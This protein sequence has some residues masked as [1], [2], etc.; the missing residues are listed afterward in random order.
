M[1]TR[2]ALKKG[3]GFW[4]AL[5]LVVVLSLFIAAPPLLRYWVAPSG[6]EEAGRF[7]ESFR[8]LNTLFSG[9]AADRTITS[10]TPEEFTNL[11]AAIQTYEGWKEGRIIK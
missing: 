7:G 3:A 10:L 1:K 5:T 11:L 4:A 2:T 8:A 9:L 6:W